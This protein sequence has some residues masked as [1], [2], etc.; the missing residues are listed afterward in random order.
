M[1]IN[2]KLNLLGII[3]LYDKNNNFYKKC[4]IKNNIEIFYTLPLYNL[5]LCKIIDNDKWYYV[6]INESDISVGFIFDTVFIKE[7]QQYKK[8][9]FSKLWKMLTAA[10]LPKH[11]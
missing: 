8:G 5:H 6:I 4:I 9:V 2:S 11:Q 7:T 1:T 3:T 10:F